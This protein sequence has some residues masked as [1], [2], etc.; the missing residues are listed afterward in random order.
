MIFKPSLW[1]ALA[2]GCF[3]LIGGTSCSTMQPA[4]SLGVLFD[5]ETNLRPTPQNYRHVPPRDQD[6]TPTPMQFTM[7][8]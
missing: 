1:L 8:F 4:G 2:T 3:T 6:R 5:G 7:A